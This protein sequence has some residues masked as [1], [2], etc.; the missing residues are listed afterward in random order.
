MI[1]PFLRL[2]IIYIVVILAAVLFFKRDSVMAMLG[3]S[4]GGAE[5]AAT[6]DEPAKIAEPV[7]TI[8]PEAEAASSTNTT[9]EAAPQPD[10]ADA[11]QPPKYPTNETA[12]IVAPTTPAEA[13]ASGDD[14]IQTRLDEARQA[15]WN[16]DLKGAEAS[17]KGLIND[18]P[19]N[20]DIKGELGNL[21]FT[22]RRMDEAAAMY[23]Q[24]G[25]QLIKDGNPQQVM[26]LIGVLQNIAPDKAAD[27]RN[28]LS[29]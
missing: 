29:Q 22:Q 25:L 5:I 15:Y 7:A 13:T 8:E 6:A 14:D 24:A 16:R 3:M 2:V 11:A 9:T 26:G 17:Y 10:T 21:Y 4:S 28:R 18:A 23:H 27:L 1:M 20:A 19:D 12:Q